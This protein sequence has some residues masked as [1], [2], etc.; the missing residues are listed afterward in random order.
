MIISQVTKVTAEVT[1]AFEKLI[2]QLNTSSPL[3]T[4]KEL[5]SLIS[6]G[7]T[8]L[9]AGIEN[10]IIMGTIS[11]VIYQIPTGRKAWI[12][13]VIVDKSARGQGYG[14]QLMLHALEFLKTKD[15]L[16]VNLTS[17]PSREAANKLY[18]NMGFN[19][20]ETNVYRFEF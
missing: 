12:E 10:D 14:K 18:H 15:V 4:F 6:S 7:N 9:F 11:V 19:L 17:H 16:F 8:Y 2:P 1:A 3:P 20:R 5:E 13:D